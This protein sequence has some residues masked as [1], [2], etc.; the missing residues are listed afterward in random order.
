ME[1]KTTNT[2]MPL[3]AHMRFN[4][5]LSMKSVGEVLKEFGN[6]VSREKK[7]SLNLFA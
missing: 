1:I 4:G 5:N 3:N 2:R 7:V 6:P